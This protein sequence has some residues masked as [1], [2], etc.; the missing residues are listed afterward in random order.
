LCSPSSTLGNDP[1]APG[2]RQAAV[3]R[4]ESGGC[5]RCVY[6]SGIATNARQRVGSSNSTRHSGKHGPDAVRAV[7]GEVAEPRVVR[8]ARAV[9]PV[10]AGAGLLRELN[11]PQASSARGTLDVALYSVAP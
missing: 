9:W 7:L 4:A 10:R 1:L 2:F 3:R 8:T 6:A 11:N 5:W